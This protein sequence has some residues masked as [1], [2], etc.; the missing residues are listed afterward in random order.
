MSRV[1]FLLFSLALPINAADQLVIGQP[2]YS[3]N[4]CP[5]NSIY[6]LAGNTFNQLDWA[7]L[8]YALNSPARTKGI[9]IRTTCNIIIPIHVPYR[10]K[11]AINPM[12]WEGEVNLPEHSES[13]WFA[14][15]YFAGDQAPTVR[16][17]WKG[18]INQNFKFTDKTA[19]SETRWSDCGSDV[20]LRIN[21]SLFLRH[22]SVSKPSE[23][24]FGRLSSSKLE[25][26]IRQKEC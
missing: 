6:D 23:I 2:I 4:G 14:E 19:T 20:N 12:T 13:V 3:G 8:S 21:T 9:Q 5:T 16:R 11:I 15:Y 7:F 17:R 25:G 26:L 1:I 10:K 18:P 24:S 22:F